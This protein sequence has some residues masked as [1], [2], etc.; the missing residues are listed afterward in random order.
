MVNVSMVFNI[1]DFVLLG[2]KEMEQLRYLY[3]MVA[4]VIYL[5]TIFLCTL[6]VY[7][8]WAEQSL[9]EPMYIF[10]CNLVGNVIVGSSAF[11]P[12]LAIDLLSG[13][14]T[15]S[16]SECLTQAFCIQSFA[17]VEILTF[18]IMAYDRY[19]AVGFPLRY[20]SLM[21]NKKALQF[22]TI[23][24][25]IVLIGRL[26][27]VM[28]VVR[29]TL[30]GDSI[31][32]VYCETTSLVRLACASTA[33]NDI[34]G[35]TW[36]LLTDIGSLMIVIYCYIRTFLVCMNISF[37]ASQKAIHTLVTHIITFSTFMAASLFVG[38]KYRLN[39]GSLPTVTHVIISR[40]ISSVKLRDAELPGEFRE[41]ER[42]F[43]NFRRLSHS[44]EALP[45][46]ERLQAS[47]MRRLAAHETFGD[48]RR[49]RRQ[50]TS[51]CLCQEWY[52]RCADAGNR[53]QIPMEAFQKAI[54]T[55]VTHII[56]FSTFMAVSF[57]NFKLEV[58]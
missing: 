48:L 18:T 16:L 14:T 49:R 25:L 33:V 36:T 35:T 9:H 3:S 50:C 55:L 41:N 4:L 21:T 15:I 42:G 1:Q 23:I 29:L 44:P 27:G 45:A 6:I 53:P 52:G 56:T 10:I 20:H 51:H 46:A 37:E 38:F 54:D 5:C 28:L 2:L 31:N 24:W 12:K 43:R 17:F 26:V 8:V 39:S 47:P 13:C 40:S 11:L 19:L 22:L 34:W 30:C 7:V 32:N 58:K 57:C